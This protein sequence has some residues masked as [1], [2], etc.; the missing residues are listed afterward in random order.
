MLAGCHVL[1]TL[2]LL[3]RG[4]YDAGRVAGWRRGIQVGPGVGMV[5]RL[6][7]TAPPAF[8]GVPIA[9]QSGLGLLVADRGHLARA[10]GDM[11]AGDAPRRPAVLAMT[12]S[13]LDPSIAPDGRHNTTLWA[14]WYPYALHGHSDGW[15]AVA[16]A[17]RVGGGGRRLVGGCAPECHTCDRFA[18]DGGRGVVAMAARAG[19]PAS[20]RCAKSRARRGRTGLRADLVLEVWSLFTWWWGRS[21]TCSS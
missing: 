12:F 3:A 20:H 4:G 1:T 17:C 21:A 5:L 13:G 2:D 16:D 14:Q 18:V 7:T 8:S 6:G 15:A 19:F 10:R 11:L 9:D